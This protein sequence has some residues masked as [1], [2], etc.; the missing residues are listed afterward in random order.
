MLQVDFLIPRQADNHLAYVINDVISLKNSPFDDKN[1]IIDLFGCLITT[2]YNIFK[3]VKPIDIPFINCLPI[4]YKETYALYLGFG[5]NA[6]HSTWVKKYYP[7]SI[8]SNLE[9]LKNIAEILRK[10]GQV[11]HIISV[12]MLILY[13]DNNTSY[14]ILSINNGIDYNQYIKEMENKNITSFWRS[15]PTPDQNKLLVFQLFG[16][17]EIGRYVDYAEKSYVSNL[18]SKLKWSKEQ[19]IYNNS[20]FFRFTDRILEL[21]TK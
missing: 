21:I 5:R 20:E 3:L 11:F 4:N 13:Y 18:D 10:Q 2:Y 9:K 6:W 14:G 7:N 1:Y 16:N 8:H 15:L 19:T 12:P 17:C